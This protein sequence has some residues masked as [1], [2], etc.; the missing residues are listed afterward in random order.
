MEKTGVHYDALQAIQG[1][2][3]VWDVWNINP[4]AIARYDLFQDFFDF[5]W[6]EY[7]F[8]TP[9]VEENASQDA[10]WEARRALGEG[11]FGKVGLWSKIDANG[12]YGE[13]VAIKQRTVP[14]NDNDL[15]YDGLWTTNLAK[16]AYFHDQLSKMAWSDFSINPLFRYKHYTE[17]RVAHLY[18]DFAPYGTLHDLAER[19]RAWDRFFPE[20]CEFHH[21]CELGDSSH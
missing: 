4:P 7:L 11:G 10:Q 3:S 19:Y 12:D 5:D 1:R 14:P 15:E 21:P 17:D 13:S 18:M 16:E 2:P 9:N 6:Q 20:L 8:S